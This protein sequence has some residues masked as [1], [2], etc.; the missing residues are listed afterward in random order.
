MSQQFEKHVYLV[1]HMFANAK[2]IVKLRHRK[3]QENPIES[4]GVV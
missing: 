3:L 1:N 4:F 2:S